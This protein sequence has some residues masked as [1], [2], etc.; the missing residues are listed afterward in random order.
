MRSFVA[1]SA[2]LSFAVP[3]FAAVKTKSVTYEHAGTKCIGHL[4]WDD[5][6]TGKRPGILVVHE[7][8]GLD[9]YAKKR[10]EQLAGMG[11][12]AF[13]CDM[14]GDGKLAKHP[15]DARKFVGEVRK[16]ADVWRGRALSALKV[17]KDHEAVDSTKLAAIG[18]CFG[19]A[20][21]MQMAYTGEPLKA[22]ASFHGGFPAPEP[23]QAKAIKCKVLI[24]HG[25][26]DP[27]IQDSALQA[28]RKALEEA[29]VDYEMIYYGGALHSFTVPEASKHG[30][31]G[32]GYQEAA[33]K[34][35]W[36]TMK[37]LFYEVFQ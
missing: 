26:A 16:N 15:D 18:Y 17:L 10:A 36:Q 23:A 24:C 21:V 28:T 32:L 2:V 35:S 8:M 12:V 37:N 22:V 33:D 7:W 6:K 31:A 30:V 25:A 34:R 1:F 9:D 11:Y 14:Y 13:A 5:A 19:G 20:T 29:K 4:A 27:L 3:S